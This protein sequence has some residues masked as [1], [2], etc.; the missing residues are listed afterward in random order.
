MYQKGYYWFL[1]YKYKLFSLKHFK[2]VSSAKA[3]QNRIYIE[4]TLCKISNE[5]QEYTRSHLNMA[6]NCYYSENI[7][8]DCGRCSLFTIQHGQ[9]HVLL[10]LVSICI[11][12]QMIHAN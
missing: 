7:P 8:A 11:V 6:N 3:F 5:Y 12:I 9:I 1:F 2:M 10:E 4:L